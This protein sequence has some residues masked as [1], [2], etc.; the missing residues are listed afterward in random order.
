MAEIEL[1]EFSVAYYWP[2]Q[3]D[4]EIEKYLSLSYPKN[5]S[6]FLFPYSIFPNVPRIGTALL[7]FLN[8]PNEKIRIKAGNF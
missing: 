6:I 1:Y 4:Q 8:E 7:K 3:K 2:G 5:I